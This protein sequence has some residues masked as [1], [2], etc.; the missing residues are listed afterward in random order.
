MLV[1]KDNDT[2]FLVIVDL[3]TKLAEVLNEDEDRDRFEAELELIHLN[4]LN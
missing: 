2:N 4:E 1:D 3:A